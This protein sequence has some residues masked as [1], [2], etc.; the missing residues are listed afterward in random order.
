[1][2]NIL[3]TTFFKYTF[4]NQNI[5]ILNTISLKYVSH[6]IVSKKLMLDQEMTWCHQAASYYLRQV[7]PDLCR[8][9][10]SLSH[11]DVFSLILVVIG[12]GNGFLSDPA[13]WYF[14]P[15]GHKELT[16]WV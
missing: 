10:A 8:H 2:A 5:Q 4:M 1:M 9:M 12:S 11:N 3:Q 6:G 13:V 7:D 14:A 15:L 16:H